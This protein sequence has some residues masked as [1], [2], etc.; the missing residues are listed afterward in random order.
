MIAQEFLDCGRAQIIC[1]SL[2]ASS[3]TINY[4]KRGYKLMQKTYFKEM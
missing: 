3:P 4:E 2:I 1:T